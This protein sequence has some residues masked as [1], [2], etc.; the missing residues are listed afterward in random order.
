MQEAPFVVK[1]GEARLA[2]PGESNS[3]MA[4]S[5]NSR[6]IVSRASTFPQPGE[7]SFVDKEVRH[8]GNASLRLEKFTANQYGHGRVMQ[9]IKVEPHRCYRVS[10]WVKTEGL[11][12][13]NAFLS[14]CLPAIVLWPPVTSTLRPQRLAEL[15]MLCNSLENNIVSL[16]AGLWGGKAGKLWL[17]DLSIE[18]VGP[19]NVLHRPGTPVKVQNE[20][21]SV[22]YAEGKDYA[23]LQDPQLNPFRD[24]QDALPLKVLAGGRIHDGDH[25]RVS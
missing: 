8:S 23:P 22:V 20:D 1:D 4:D 5:R 25:L 24:D 7:I 12:P 15:T 3:R 9:S 19:V 10:V 17:D 18:E 13:A 11:E 16:Y 14:K 21:G 2:K 6:K